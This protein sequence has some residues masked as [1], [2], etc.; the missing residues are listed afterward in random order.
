MIKTALFAAALVGLTAIGAGTSSASAAP[1]YYGGWKKSHSHY[2][3]SVVR[4]QTKCFGPRRVQLGYN[5]SG[6][7]VSRTVVGRCFSPRFWNQM[8]KN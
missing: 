6:D 1:G 5:R 4:T 7:V 2:G 8:N 3:S